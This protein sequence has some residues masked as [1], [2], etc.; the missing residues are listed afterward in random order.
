MP[1]GSDNLPGINVRIK[2][3]YQIIEQLKLAIKDYEDKIK[4][5]NSLDHLK[6]HSTVK[7]S[8]MAL[9]DHNSLFAT[10]LKTVKDLSTKSSRE[11]LVAKMVSNKRLTREC[12]A[13]AQLH[14]LILKQ[15]NEIKKLQKDTTKFYSP[16]EPSKIVREEFNEAQKEALKKAQEKLEKMYKAYDKG[17]ENGDI[18]DVNNFIQQSGAKD[19]GTPGGESS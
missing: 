13:I 17:I 11:D 19:K 10:I 18:S 5:L 15:E 7:E 8:K 2:V 14:E 4:E 16:E 12:E 6:L 1:T 9:G 3:Y